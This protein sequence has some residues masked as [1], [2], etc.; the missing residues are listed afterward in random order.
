MRAM[1]RWRLVRLLSKKPHGYVWIVERLTD[2]GI[3]RGYFKFLTGRQKYYGGP[4]AANELIGARLAQEIGLPVAELEYLKFR[5]YEGIVSIAVQADRRRRWRELPRAV[6]YD[7]H[8]HFVNPEGLFGMF[9]FD[10]FTYNID[11][12]SGK[13]LIAFRNRGDVLYDWYLI[14]HGHA[15]FG[16]RYK[17]NQIGHWSHPV[18]D[19]IWPYYYLPRGLKPQ[20]QQF[21]QLE[22]W[23][24][25]CESLSDQTLRAI[26]TGIPARFL[27]RPLAGE[28][29]SM[30]QHRRSRLS[31][32]LRAWFRDVERERQRSTRSSR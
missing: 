12:R 19:R 14:D 13:N 7:V 23:I 25:A 17:W 16:S 20:I 30:L 1:R 8:R 3:Q 6:R 5:G 28:V 18:W 9:V 10:V 22:P 29:L 32:I 27:P 24:E 4:M 15:L 31:R 26:L 21:S 11:R 2:R